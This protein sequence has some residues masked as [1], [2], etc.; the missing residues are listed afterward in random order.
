MQSLQ[1]R[2]KERELI[3]YINLDYSWNDYYNNNQFDSLFNH[4]TYSTETLKPA[5]GNTY[6]YN[7]Y[8]HDLIADYGSAINS[9]KGNNLLVEKCSFLDCEATID[10][11][12]IRVMS[13]NVIAAFICG[14]N[15]KSTKNDGFST[16]WSD[17]NRKISSF[18][19]SSISHCTSGNTYTIALAYGFVH[20]KS[21][22]LSN[23]KAALYSTIGCLPNCVLNEKESLGGVIS[24]C[25]VFNNTATKECCIRLEYYGSRKS[26][27]I[28]RSNI[29]NNKG[30]NIIMSK[31]ET[32]ISDC[33]ILDNGNPYFYTNDENSTITLFDCN[34]DNINGEGSGSF[35]QIQTTNPFIVA[36]T[37]FETGNCH[38]L[39]VQFP[40][41]KKCQ[42]PVEKNNLRFKMIT[43]SLFIFL[44]WSS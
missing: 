26:H 15:G 35:T 42:T 12:S 7:C 37:F 32:K 2:T 33:S 10:T 29:M 30:K 23:N 41:T 40:N 20:I 8:F 22:N 18:Y 27:E 38:N 43:P 44:L 34:T 36:L 19:D 6:V 1:K 5:E 31:G 28:K 14:Q 21:V 9:T 39:F 25:S 13:G 17:G 4:I 16:F 11:S 24:Y 3:K